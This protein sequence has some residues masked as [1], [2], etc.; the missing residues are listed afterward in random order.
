[1]RKDLEKKRKE[2]F[3]SMNKILI[4]ATPNHYMYSKLK[5]LPSFVDYDLN[6]L[7]EAD[8]LFDFSLTK[9]EEKK[10]FIQK[11]QNK[12]FSDLTL[13]DHRDIEVRGK[14][15]SVFASPNSK[16]EFVARDEDKELIV[17]VLKDLSLAP[18]FVTDPRISF[19]FPRILV[20]IINEAFFAIEEKVAAANDI[21]TAMLFGVNYPKGPMEWG[22]LAG[23]QHVSQI[24]DELF[25]ITNDQRYLK[26]KFLN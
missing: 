12:I 14:F 4:T 23:L 17:Q 8:T 3:I 5:S 22:K 16:I 26:S 24:L 20:Q 9:K 15:S 13:Y 18:L 21:D 7:V 1:V 19:V 10:D 25:L 11:H 6:M 2:D